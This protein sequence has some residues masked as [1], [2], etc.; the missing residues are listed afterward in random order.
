MPPSAARV[1]A[2]ISQNIATNIRQLREARSMTQE[3]LARE[4]GV[5]RPTVASLESGSANPTISILIKVATGLQVPVEELISPPRAIGKLYPVATLSSRKRGE[6]WVRKLLPDTIHSLELDRMELPVGSRMIGAPHRAGT[7]EYL[8]CE[9]GEVEITVSGNTWKL[10]PGD[11]FVFRG[12]QKHSY[13][14][15]GS[16]TAIAYSVILFGE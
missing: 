8:A 3:Q 15:P 9:S 2:P 11:V 10:G 13:A 16:R 12:D 7:R 14:N 4:A 5:P 1:S 6:V